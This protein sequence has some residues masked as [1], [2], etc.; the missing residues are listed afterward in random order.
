MPA[1]IEI[2]DVQVRRPGHPGKGVVAWASCVVSGIKLN[3]IVVMRL[4]DG[5]LALGFPARFSRSHGKF[6]HIE[7]VT[8]EAKRAL[9]DAILGELRATLGTEREDRGP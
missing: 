5:S 7:P 6:P 3:N 4:D 2:S 8:A 9:E 1:P